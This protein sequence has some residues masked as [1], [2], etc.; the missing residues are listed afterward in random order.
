MHSFK[1][2]RGPFRVSF[3]LL[4]TVT[5]PHFPDLLKFRMSLTVFK[6]LVSIF[7]TAVYVK[8]GLYREDSWSK[9]KDL[10]PCVQYAD[11]SP[12]ET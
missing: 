7:I 10:G 2:Y 6:L 12:T 3:C 4:T 5:P 8:S 11:F 1:D 9:A